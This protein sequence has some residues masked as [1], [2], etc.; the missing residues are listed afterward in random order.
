MIAKIKPSPRF[1][2]KTFRAPWV[3]KR[4]EALTT[5]PGRP[6]VN[7]TIRLSLHYYSSIVYHGE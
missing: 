1:K 2:P 7:R 6:C 4:G 5:S 3:T